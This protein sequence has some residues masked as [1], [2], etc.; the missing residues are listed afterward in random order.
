MLRPLLAVSAL[1]ATVVFA[2]AQDAPASFRMNLGT[3]ILL[4][5][6][7]SQ[8]AACALPWGGDLAHGQT[9][10]AFASATV[11]YGQ[12]CVAETRSCMD[13][14]LS[15]SAPEQSCTVRPQ[16]CSTTT[17]PGA[18][19]DDGAVYLGNHVIA[20]NTY[21]LYVA[22]QS[23]PSAIRAGQV[24]ASVQHVFPEA[25]SDGKGNTDRLVAIVDESQSYP[26]AIACRAHGPE[27]YLPSMDELALMWG[28]SSDI[29]GIGP[30]LDFWSST[31]FLP[32]NFGFR[33]GSQQYQ[34]AQTQTK[35]VRC[36]RREA[37]SQ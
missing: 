28:R 7:S 32:G 15:G 12:E 10:D 25:A 13:G 11:P 37:V 21:R 31:P 19:C 22:P 2:T 1:L 24:A 14:V 30:T 27:W 9:V 29:Q 20:G 4:S 34:A 33:R 8:P 18:A 5:A 17:V 16:E 3:P 26:A 36:M 6:P 23:E 35:R